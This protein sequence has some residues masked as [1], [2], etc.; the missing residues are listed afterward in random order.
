[1]P[2]SDSSLAREGLAMLAAIVEDLSR[3]EQ[4]PT[5]VV[6]TL[7]VRLRRS[8]TAKQIADH[9]QVIWAESPAEELS[10]FQD[11][12][13]TSQA[14]LVIA[15]ESDGRLL[16][17]RRLTDAAGGLF[18]GHSLG[19]IRLC[20]DK[21]LFHDHLRK[22]SL[23]TIPT[24]LWDASAK[25]PPFSF[26]IVV[27]PRDGA[28]SVDTFLLRDRHDSETRRT[29]LVSFFGEGTEAV[30]QPYLA[31]RA[32]SA[33]ALIGPEPDHIEIFPPAEQRVSRDA[34]RLSYRGGR[35]PAS[36]VSP[37]VACEVAEV[38][39][40]TCRSLPG[41][42]GFIGFDLIVTEVA[43]HIRIVEANP[44]LTT[45]YVGYRRLT[46]DNLAQRMLFPGKAREPIEW[47]VSV[48]WDKL[49]QRAQAHHRSSRN[50]G[51][52]AANAALSPPTNATLESRAGCV[53]FNAD[54]DVRLLASSVR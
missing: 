43:P 37:D 29:E 15:P 22:C 20:G 9:A 50:G 8:S 45:S 31:G 5:R 27:K 25:S 2:L 38:I 41:L 46:R 18:L 28:G 35:I 54:G 42:A 39:R 14:T 44:R 13:S 32:L 49:A 24:M 48:G 51:V 34:G 16:E 40:A 47:N 21:L 7:D 30:V 12:A 23:P 11:L 26:P 19:A 6:T 36:E 17:R 10:L 4:G 53:E 3:C 33:A 52:T 1:G